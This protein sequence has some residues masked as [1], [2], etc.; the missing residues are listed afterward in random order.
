MENSKNSNL[1]T[2]E[3]SYLSLFENAKKCIQIEDIK[4]ALYYINL[5]TNSEAIKND[6]NTKFLCLVFSNQIFYKQKNEILCFN[7][8]KKIIKLILTK[9]YKLLSHEIQVLFLSVL[10]CSASLLDENNKNLLASLLLY[11][12]KSFI[13]ELNLDSE[14]RN[15]QLIMKGFSANMLKL[16]ECVK[17]LIIK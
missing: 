3:V 8:A 5:V 2:Q 4:N 11:N 7:Q 6:I 14:D 1:E 15:Y 12:A 10:Y 13:D 9:K 17:S 16:N